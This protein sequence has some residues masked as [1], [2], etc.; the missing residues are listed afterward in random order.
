MC[1]PL[2]PFRRDIVDTALHR[3]DIYFVSTELI[4][5]TVIFVQVK[6][7]GNSASVRIPASAMQAANLKLDDAVDVRKEDGCVVIESISE[8]HADL[9]ALLAGIT[10][11]NLHGEVDFA[12][13]VGREAF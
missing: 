5:R 8:G 9:E 13:R 7:W 4:A 10:L 11:D 12:K 3:R 1:L 6:K 2:K